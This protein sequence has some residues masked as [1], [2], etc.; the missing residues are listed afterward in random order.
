MNLEMVQFIQW[1][2]DCFF[3]HMCT[4]LSK[5]AGI[6]SLFYSDSLSDIRLVIIIVSQYALRGIFFLGDKMLVVAPI[7]KSD[8]KCNKR[9]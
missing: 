8:K 1:H 2:I 4:Q 7:K 3:N 6:F 9:I 5:S